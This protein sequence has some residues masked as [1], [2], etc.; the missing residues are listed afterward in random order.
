[1]VAILWAE[2]NHQAAI[3][4][5]HLWN[6][7]LQRFKLNL[8]CAYPIG[9]FAER[10]YSEKFSAICS[11]H[12]E[13]VPAEGYASIQY[14]TERERLV[15]SLQ[16][17]A[18]TVDAVVEERE[19]EVAHRKVVEEKLRRTEEFTR[20]IIES[21]ADCV[22]VLDIDGRIQY[23]SPAGQRSLEIS[24]PSQFLNKKWVELWRE[25]DR[26]RAQGSLSAARN[27]GVGCFQ[28]DS[29]TMGGVKKS[30]D[31]R[32]TPALDKRGNIERLVAV[33]RD[34]TELKTAQQLAIQSEKL[35]AAGRMAAT[36]AHEINNPLEAVT[37]F[38]YLAM[39]AKG[40]AGRG[41]PPSGDCGSRACAGIADCAA[42]AGVL[43][44]YFK[45]SLACCS[46]P[47]SGRPDRV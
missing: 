37:N 20:N 38:I 3:E 42:D 27:G 21:T 15:S 41:L 36:I 16:E 30:W 19:K 4:L 17:K 31:V 12:T 22:K 45:G 23:M 25:E 43:S 34:M 5:E 24:D 2:G 46:R 44:S 14:A 28:G 6:E 32:I 40:A 8:L 39:T 26:D 13:V 18:S 11:Q 9:T 29:L 10:A 33:S 47:D 7:L 1:M 35:A